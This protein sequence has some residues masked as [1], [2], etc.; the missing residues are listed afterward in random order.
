ML[1][2]MNLHSFAKQDLINFVTFQ[3]RTRHRLKSLG[4]LIIPDD[5]KGIQ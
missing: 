1:Y 4:K 5:S 2:L 3:I